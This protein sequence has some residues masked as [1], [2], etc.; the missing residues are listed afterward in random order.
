MANEISYNNVYLRALEKG[1]V[2]AYAHVRGGNEK[3]NS[4]W[5]QGSLQNKSRSWKDLHEC[6][7]YLIKEQYTHP[8]LLTLYGSSAGAITVWN[9][10]NRHPWL[11]K[12]AVMAYPFLD[13]LTSL[14]DDKLPLTI[15]DH[16]EF[17]NPNDSL[18]VYN[19]IESYCP[20]ETIMPQ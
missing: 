8:A 15:S 14:L 6:V 4:W 17:G 7:A 12:A 5:S 16:A 2:I 11:Y 20:Y 9:E 3:G 19:R 13:V 10:L 1:W 18:A